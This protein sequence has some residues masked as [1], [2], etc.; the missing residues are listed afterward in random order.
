MNI[1]TI[2]NITKAY[3]ERKLFHQA[4]FFLEEGEKAGVIGINGTGKSTLLQIIAGLEEPDEGRVIMA[5]HC[6]VRFLPQDPYFEEQE[7][8]LEAVLRD[9]RTE[10]NSS[11]IVSDAWGDGL[12]ETLRAAFR[13][14]E[15]KAGPCLR[16]A[17][18]GGNI[19]AGRTYE[20]SGQ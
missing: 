4:S 3:G 15:E 5:N 6:M 9:N 7:T 8:A 19:G 1:L 10:A 17:F 11:Y 13:G 12:R 14:T 18:P 2:D 16:S 20:P